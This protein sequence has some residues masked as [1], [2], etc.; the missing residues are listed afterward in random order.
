MVP[1]ALHLSRNTSYPWHIRFAYYIKGSL[2]KVLHRSWHLRFQSFCDIGLEP[3]LKMKVVLQAWQGADEEWGCRHW[4]RWCGEWNLNLLIR[5]ALANCCQLPEGHLHTSIHPAWVKPSNSN[6]LAQPSY[7]KTIFKQTK[8]KPP[9]MSYQTT[10]L[11]LSKSISIC[12]NKEDLKEGWI[13][14]HN[15]F[16]GRVHWEPSQA[17][18][19]YRRIKFW[20]RKQSCCQ[21]CADQPRGSGAY[22]INSVGPLRSG[23]PDLVR[24]RT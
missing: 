13:F 11:C 15:F 22:E 16:Q 2:K 1:P 3:G 6:N 23:I 7:L 8:A 9:I 18:S 17:G 20:S 5:R 4:R 14:K 10:K 12:H 21:L 19:T 24:I